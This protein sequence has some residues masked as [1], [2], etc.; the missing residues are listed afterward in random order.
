MEQGVANGSWQDDHQR[1]L[2]AQRNA[3][4]AARA[5]LP[6]VGR[7][8]PATLAGI[9]A[10]RWRSAVAA[11]RPLAI[12]VRAPGPRG[13]RCSGRF[14]AQARARLARPMVAPERISQRCIDAVEVATRTDC[15][16]GLAMNPVVCRAGA[17]QRIAS[18]AN[19]FLPNGG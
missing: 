14:F 19:L 8:F 4:R 15:A 16:E 3:G 5:K 10:L 1:R 7:Q 12:A 6:D 13:S 9:Q 18:C 11:V 2:R 17:N